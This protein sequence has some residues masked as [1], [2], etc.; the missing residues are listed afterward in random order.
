[1]ESGRLQHRDKALAYEVSRGQRRSVGAAPWPSLEA[2]ESAT[3]G[4]AFI[5][6]TMLLG[7]RNH[8]RKGARL[9]F[10]IG[11]HPD[12][13]FVPKKADNHRHN[14]FLFVAGRGKNIELH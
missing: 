6:S 5:A 12:L 13:H 3:R 11:W 14:N 1:M 4:D 8:L 2:Q 10:Q 9:G 7:W